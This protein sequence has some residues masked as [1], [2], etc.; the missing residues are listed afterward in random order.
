MLFV[1]FDA[2]QFGN[3]H[4]CSTLYLMWLRFTVRKPN[5]RGGG[6]MLRRLTSVSALCLSASV[7]AQ[8][9]IPD[10][11]PE[12]QRQDRQRQELRERIEVQPWSPSGLATQTPPHQ[13]IPEEQ[14][15]ALIDR[16]VIQGVLFSEALQTALS[17]VNGDDPPYFASHGRCLGSQ[18]VTLLIQ[19]EVA[20][21][22]RS[23]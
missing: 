1:L 12:L 22:F 11:S 4:L 10:P 6:Y 16:V 3:K 7:A 21:E 20:P 5:S 14:P 9:A 15:C 2:L 17:G 18:G 8:S 19:R 13:K 23:A